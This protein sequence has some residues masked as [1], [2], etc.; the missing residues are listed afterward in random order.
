MNRVRSLAL[1]GAA[2]LVWGSAGCAPSTVVRAEPGWKSLEIRE[3]LT[4][5]QCWMTAVDLLTRDWDIEMMDKNSGYI[6]TAWHYGVGGQSAQAYR[7][8]IT[9]KFPDTKKP[10]VVEVKTEAQWV[11]PMGNAN[12]WVPGYDTAMQRDVFSAIGGRVGRSVP[13]E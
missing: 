9:V 1:V 12:V 11:D 5:D 3:D 13:R 10:A 7:G 6:R 4:Y 8:R 2:V